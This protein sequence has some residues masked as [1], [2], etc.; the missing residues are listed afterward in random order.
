MSLTDG[1]SHSSLESC[2]CLQHPHE[3]DCIS[4]SDGHSHSF[5]ETRLCLQ[6]TQDHMASSD[7]P[8]HSTYMSMTI[9]HSDGP[10]HRSLQTCLCLL[11]PHDHMTFFD[12]LPHRAV[13][14]KHAPAFEGHGA[15]SLLSIPIIDGTDYNC[16]EGPHFFNLPASTASL[17][18]QYSS[19]PVLSDVTIIIV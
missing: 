13:P 14:C 6:H 15:E 18:Q 2:S 3:F 16:T 5:L 11:H 9:S 19:L 17:E 8:S 12:S 7:G 10:S 1:P 4:L